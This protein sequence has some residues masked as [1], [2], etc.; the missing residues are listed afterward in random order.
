MVRCAVPGKPA[1]SS[2]RRR[3]GEQPTQVHV[4]DVVVTRSLVVYQ[5]DLAVQSSR[6]RHCRA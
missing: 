4:A 6:M 3:T 5:L 2:R 1:V